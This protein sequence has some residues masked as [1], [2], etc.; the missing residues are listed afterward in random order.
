ML[1]LSQE[2]IGTD[3]TFLFT[4]K[5]VENIIVSSQINSNHLY[6]NV[7]YFSFGA[8]GYIKIYFI[9]I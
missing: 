5:P 1:T 7:D 8:G 6:C 3:E 2:Y 4:L 9:S